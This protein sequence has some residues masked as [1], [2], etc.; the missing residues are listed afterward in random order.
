MLTSPTLVEKRYPCFLV[1][2]HYPRFKIQKM[3]KTM[4][5]RKDLTI[6]YR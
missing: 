2:K 1:D 5:R 4:D 3:A 6:R